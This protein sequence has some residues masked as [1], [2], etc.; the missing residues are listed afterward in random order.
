MPINRRPTPPP[1]AIKQT[2]TVM[3]SLNAWTDANDEDEDKG[4]RKVPLQAIGMGVPDQGVA[5]G[6]RQFF[7]SESDNFNF[8]IGLVIIA[9]AVIIGLETDYGRDH[10]IVA[11][12]IFNS[13]FVLEML[14]R[15]SHIGCEYFTSFKYLFDCSLVVSGSLDLWILP[16]LSGGGNSGVG[17]SF[18][19]MRLLRILRL[20]RVLRV[21]RLFRMFGQ[22][23]L[24]ITAFG[25]SLQVVLLL[26]ILVVIMIYALAIVATQLI[27]HKSEEWGD[28]KE[29]LEYYFGDIGGSMKTIFCIMFGSSWEP[30]L[31]LLTKVYPTGFVLGLFAS[32]MVVTVS[33]A[34][35]IIGLISESLIIAQQEFK[36]RKLASFSSKRKEVAAEYTE[37]LNALLEDDM[38]EFFTVDAKDLRPT[39]KGDA[40][41]SAKLMEVGIAMQPD[42]LVGLVESMTKQGTIRCSV[43]HFIEKL[44]NLS[45]NSSASQIVDVK[46]DIAINKRMLDNVDTKMN[47]LQM[48][49]NEQKQK[50]DDILKK[51]NRL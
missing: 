51:L 50:V 41:L 1:E 45:G 38:D 27:G 6:W 35:L 30:L 11:E 39:V 42:G 22:L 26:S 8:A 2:N 17:H 23:L 28:S 7:D 40:N 43:D 49:M 12:H 10:F 33:L 15:I 32:F 25:K 13:I 19:V 46:Y 14:T 4:K 47:E 44:I 48:K 24:I 18:S 9:N 3:D 34:A 29:D 5:V 20:M 31:E 37:E 16:A 36:Q 21:I